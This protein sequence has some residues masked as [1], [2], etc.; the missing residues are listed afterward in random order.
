[1]RNDSDSKKVVLI[2]YEIYAITNNMDNFKCIL[3]FSEILSK[4][5]VLFLSFF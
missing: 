2:N 4:L 3:L 1:M 5:F